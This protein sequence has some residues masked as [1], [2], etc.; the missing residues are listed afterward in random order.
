MTPTDA[1]V[2]QP[3]RHALPLDLHASLGDIVTAHPDLTRHL[4]RLGL[5]YCC[6][7]GRPLGAACAEAGL[8]PTAV[9]TELGA[10]AAA[11][12]GPAPWADLGPAQLVDHLEAVHHRYLDAELPRLSALAAK[13]ADVH[14]PRHP[15]LAEVAST[16]EDLRADLEPHLAKEERVLF[17]MVRDLAAARAAGGPVPAFHCG[18]LRNPIAVMDREHERAGELLARLRRLTGGY[19]PPEDACASYQALYRGLGELEA[20]THLHVHKESNVLFPAV[21]ALELGVDP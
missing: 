19:Q 11:G 17:P 13:V 9:A 8:D 12:T 14:G 5:D 16:F 2:A 20:D 21:V 15:E 10:L 4:E 7:G 1:P 6:G 3:S 18:S